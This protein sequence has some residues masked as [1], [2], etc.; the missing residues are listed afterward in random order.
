MDVHWY[1]SAL[2]MPAS[3]CCGHRQKQPALTHNTM[4]AETALNAYIYTRGPR[5]VTAQTNQLGA[6]QSKQIKPCLA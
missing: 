5:R 4:D 1:P 3:A 2:S 6:N